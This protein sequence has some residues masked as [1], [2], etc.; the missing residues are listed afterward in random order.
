MTNLGRALVSSTALLGLVTFGAC[1]NS[2]EGNTVYGNAGPGGAGAAGGAA[3]ATGAGPQGGVGA[4]NGVGGS[5]GGIGGVSG[6]S[7]ASGSAGSGGSGAQP[8]VIDNCP[9]SLD[10]AAAQAL[11]TGGTPDASMKFLYPYDKTVFPRGL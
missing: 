4:V 5:L 3:G 1:S 8:T 11:R 2:K 9:G 10:A 6:S 7:G